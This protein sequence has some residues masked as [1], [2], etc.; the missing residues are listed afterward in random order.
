MSTLLDVLAR[1]TGSQKIDIAR[2]LLTTAEGGGRV[3]AIIL[4]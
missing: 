3:K 4:L 1:K 2:M